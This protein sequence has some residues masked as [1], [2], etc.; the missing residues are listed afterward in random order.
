M[1]TSRHVDSHADQ[2]EVVFHKDSGCIEQSF[3]RAELSKVGGSEGDR[4]TTQS[5]G[6]GVL[7]DQSGV[8]KGGSSP[9]RGCS[10]YCRADAA[11]V[12]M[13]AGTLLGTEDGVD[14]LI[15]DIHFVM[16]ENKTSWG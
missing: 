14:G 15:G 10:G 8:T 11:F 9:G 2:L 6:L 4:G 3:G 5:L 12:I 16:K 1:V 7:S 13:A